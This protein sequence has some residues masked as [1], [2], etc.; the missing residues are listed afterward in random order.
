[1]DGSF[2]TLILSYIILH[3]HLFQIPLLGV[4]MSSYIL[5]YL[6]LAAA[7]NHL[8]YVSANANVPGGQPSS[9]DGTYIQ[10]P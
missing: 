3:I 2:L 8:D 1:M 4:S 5:S 10:S 6:L 9:S 7:D